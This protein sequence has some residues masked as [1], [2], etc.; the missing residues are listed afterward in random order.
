MKSRRDFWR[1]W[2]RVGVAMRRFVRHSLFLLGAAVSVLAAPAN[3]PPE[4]ILV[5]VA[6]QHSAYERTAQFV[7]RV[8]QLQRENAGVP[9]AVLIDGDSL[10]QGNAVARRTAGAID[11]A[12]F[13]ALAKRAPTVVNL[14]NHEPEFFDVTE[15][16]LRF[17]AAG[18][19][20]ISGNLRNP[21]TGKPYAPAFITLRLGAHELTIVGVTTD[22]LS[23]FRV[24]VRP[25]LD[26]ADP[27][28]WATQN[29][30]TLF[31]GARLPV[32]LSHAGLR[33][34]RSILPMV[35]DGTLFAGAHDHLQF[36]HREK[37]T[38]YVHSGSW[39][40]VMSVARLRRGSD[41]LNWEIEQ[42]PLSA[43]DPADPVL[44]KR[45]RETLAQHLTP[46]ETV[47]VGRSPRAL[48][49]EDAARFAVEAARKAAD[50]DVALIGAT[51]FGAGLPAGDVSRYAFDAF[52]RFDGTLHVAEVEGAH[53]RRILAK[54]NQGPDTPFAHRGGENLVAVGTATLVPGRTYRFVT[55]DWIAKNAQ[56][57]LGD[58]PPE[59]TERADLK[60]KAAVIAALQQKP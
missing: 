4:A 31:Q 23:T 19:R 52:V 59:L 14:G 54:A 29:L 60:L 49:P 34:D 51:T 12:M 7:G 39:L 5:I 27:V 25:Q 50:A 35:P 32:V 38:L 47:L 45:V 44:A 53:L 6:D 1:K 55:S 16:V 20:V 22:Q 40:S 17:E 24:A 15:T 36:V 13:A 26:L 43:S 21:A 11:F 33:A 2:C 58:D 28:V 48:A 8:D 3:L 30:P 37:R 57:Y 10:E 41:G 46:E 56:K 18:A 9:M 42:L